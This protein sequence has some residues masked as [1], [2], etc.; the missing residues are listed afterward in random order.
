[1][2]QA[3]EI[4]TSFAGLAFGNNRKSILQKPFRRRKQCRRLQIQLQKDPGKRKAFT[5]QE[6]S[7]EEGQKYKINTEVSFNKAQM[8]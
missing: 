2:P 5:N 7:C 1:M 3:T 6:K 4:W 8:Y